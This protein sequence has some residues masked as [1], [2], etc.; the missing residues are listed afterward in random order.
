MPSPALVPFRNSCYCELLSLQV[1]HG[2][3]NDAYFAWATEP[4]AVMPTAMAIT[5]RI[6]KIAFPI[7]VSPISFALAERGR[8][9]VSMRR[10]GKRRDEGSA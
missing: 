5:A 3:L 7:A 4:T 10:F 2:P 9:R 1:S 8:P 6:D